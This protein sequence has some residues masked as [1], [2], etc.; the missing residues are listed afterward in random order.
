M[1]R[2][3]FFYGKPAAARKKLIIDGEVRLHRVGAAKRT[4]CEGRVGELIAN[5]TSI[6]LGIETRTGK[7]P[8]AGPPR[9]RAR[10]NDAASSRDLFG[11]PGAGTPFPAR[12][13]RRPVELRTRAPL[14]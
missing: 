1:N 14:Y 8:K 6:D 9:S 13:G 2:R 10:S 4:T 12:N 11:R 5:E 3:S 7:P